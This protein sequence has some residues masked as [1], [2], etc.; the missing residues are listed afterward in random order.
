M[1]SREYVCREV[2]TEHGG[3]ITIETELIRCKDCKWYRAPF[4]GESK[5][6]CMLY[7]DFKTFSKNDD[8]FCNEA[9]PKEKVNG[10]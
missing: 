9:M 2:P 7:T 6:V 8:D 4:R 5:G 10:K 3:Y 1:A